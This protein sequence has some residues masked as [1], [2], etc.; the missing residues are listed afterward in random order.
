MEPAARDVEAIAAMFN[1]VG[2][3][4]C[5]APELDETARCKNTQSQHYS[6]VSSL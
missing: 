6:P 4:S 1:R 2:E 3:A 5:A